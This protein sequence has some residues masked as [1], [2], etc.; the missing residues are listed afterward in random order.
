[1]SASRPSRAGG[2]VCRGRRGAGGN[3]ARGTWPTLGELLRMLGSRRRR[4]ID[5][6]P[7]NFAPTQEMAPPG[8]SAPTA[9]TPPL[10]HGVLRF[11]ARYT[12]TPWSDGGGLSLPPLGATYRALRHTPARSHH[13]ELPMPLRWR[14]LARRRG[15]FADG[16]WQDLQYAAALAT[17]FNLM[18][19][20]SFQRVRRRRASGC[21]RPAHG[22]GAPDNRNPLT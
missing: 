4:S 10:A 13:R 19:D 14:P 1:M 22:G 8:T 6:E 3:A 2:G 5:W 9:P 7:A 18:T 20:P 12:P 17:T 21:R 11:C 15:G 16:R